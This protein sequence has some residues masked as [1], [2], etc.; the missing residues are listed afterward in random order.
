MRLLI[1]PELI[2]QDLVL[3][4]TAVW[5][6]RLST[7]IQIKLIGFRR[8]D[9]HPENSDFVKSTSEDIEDVRA[10]FQSFG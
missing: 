3:Q 5:V 6:S 4:Q 8:H 2:I 9:E 1:I 7:D 10:V